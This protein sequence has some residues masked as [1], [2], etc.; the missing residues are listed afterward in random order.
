MSSVLDDAAAGQGVE[1]H[2]QRVVSLPDETV[3]GYE[4]LARWPGLRD[5]GP[6]DVFARARVNGTLD[7]LDHHC[8]GSAAQA[9]MRGGA[10]SGMLL[11]INVE[12]TTAALDPGAAAKVTAAAEECHLVFELTERELL[13]NPSALL[14]KVAALRAAGYSIALDDIGVHSDSLAL[15]DLVAPDILKLDM[16]L[17]QNQP[18]RLQARTIAAVIAHHERTGATILAEGIETDEHLEQA[19]AY[20]ATL[21]QGYRFGHPGDLLVPPQGSYRP[22]HTTQSPL[23]ARASAFDLAAG[24]LMT[25]AVR[26]PTV[27]QLSRHIEHLAAVADSPPIVLAAVQ[28]AK[29]FTGLTVDV[30]LGLAERSPLVA[31]LGGGASRAPCP[32]V[33]WVSLDDGDPLLAEWG[34]VVL[35]PD[36]AA[37]LLARERPGAGL[38]P[39]GE[40]R[41]DMVM[42]FDRAR[43]TTAA[44]CMLD[45]FPDRPGPG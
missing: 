20:G 40:K 44:R 15:L 18:N 8:V 28:E 26:K 29:Y 3:V 4:A 25:R 37:G 39:D 21:G 16:Q 9:A 1:P 35:G 32:G 5:V 6:L 33:K 2:F 31:V 10:T 30:Y 12:P 23:P 38:S 27:L 41:F 11:L 34:V 42:T 36:M 43:V 7:A 14:R 19:L 45:R 22:A 17:V 13:T 24:G